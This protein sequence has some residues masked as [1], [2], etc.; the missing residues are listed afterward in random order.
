MDWTRRGGCFF[1]PKSKHGFWTSLRMLRR[2]LLGTGMDNF[3]LH[4]LLSAGLDYNARASFAASC[5]V[6]LFPP[7]RLVLTETGRVWR[8]LGRLMQV[9][10]ADMCDSP[11]GLFEWDVVGR[12]PPDKAA[13]LF[14]VET[15]RR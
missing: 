4:R 6:T 2:V 7:R 8:F 11:S 15:Q 1:P 12:L 9:P 10:A 14:R 5:F 13:I 3:L